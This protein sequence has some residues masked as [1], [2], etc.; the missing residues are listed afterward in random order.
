MPLTNIYEHLLCSD[1]ALST[2]VS[3]TS[4]AAVS[5]W[6]QWSKRRQEILK[7]ESNVFHGKAV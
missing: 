7:S 3:K 1:N 2:A 4:P 5:A 6:S